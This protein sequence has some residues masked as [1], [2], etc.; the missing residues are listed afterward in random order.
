MRTELEDLLHISHNLR[1]WQ[2]YWKEN[3]GSH[4]RDR[5][6]YWQQKM[7]EKLD[8]HGLTEHNNTR[9]IKIYKS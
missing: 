2:K 5:M 4:S 7:D 8:S 3:Y 1:F 6:N 9:A